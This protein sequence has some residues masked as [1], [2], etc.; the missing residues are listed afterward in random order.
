[1]SGFAEGFVTGF[2][3]T[4][5][6]D[7]TTRNRNAEDYFN[8]Q[9]E[10]ARTIGVENRKKSQAA[11]NEGVTVA[12]QLQQMGVP[13][14]VIMAIANQ[15]PGDLGNFYTQVAEA[16]SQGVVLDQAFFDDFVKISADFKAPD[17]DFQ[18]FF[19]RVYTPIMNTATKD[20]QA[21][22]NDCKGGLFAA[23]M[24]YSAMDNA[25]DRLENTEIMNGMSAADLIAYG[26]NAIPNRPAGDGTVSYDFGK[27]GESVRRTKGPD[28]LSISEQGRLAD[29]FEKAKDEVRRDLIKKSANETTPEEEAE[30]ARMAAE[31]LLEI[32]GDNPDA[33]AAIK[34]MLG[35]VVETVAPQDES[36]TSDELKTVFDTNKP[37]P[38][39]DPKNGV[40]NPVPGDRIDVE[41]S[42]APIQIEKEAGLEA[43]MA[44][45]SMLNGAPFQF[46]G[47][48]GDGTSTW[49]DVTGKKRIFKNADLRKLANEG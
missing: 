17:E 48:N 46:S 15:N 19:T 47:D 4:L 12:K 3:N 45:S 49:I 6:E 23:F 43:T 39:E 22:N 28:S 29:D 32:Y 2:A 21:F 8:K 37:A 36:I 16:A 18:T 10:L 9:V 44:D 33:V 40:K 35:P 34:R 5:T 27:Y 42:S 13:K 7:I 31:K 25:R 24:G 38:K 11:I 41:E 14:N 1:M 30:V 26:D 20:P